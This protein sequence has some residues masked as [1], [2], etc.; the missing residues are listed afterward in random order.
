MPLAL[1]RARM[2]VCSRTTRGPQAQLRSHGLLSPRPVT[3]GSPGPT[4]L[5]VHPIEF[6]TG[7]KNQHVRSKR[8]QTL[9]RPR[10]ARRATGHT[11]HAGH[12][13]HRPDPPGT[14]RFLFLPLPFPPSRCHRRGR[15]RQHSLAGLHRPLVATSPEQ[16]RSG[17]R[18]VPAFPP[19][20]PIHRHR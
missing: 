9:P 14:R 20:S 5:G 3:P 16:P 15:A 17:H 19:P 11:G 10:S 13:G 8:D 2:V 4:E 6:N 18:T 12:A 7:G 1:G